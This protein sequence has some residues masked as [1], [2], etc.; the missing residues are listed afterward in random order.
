MKITRLYREV[1]QKCRRDKRAYING[2]ISEA[3]EAARTREQG[4]VYPIN[5]K[6]SV[7][8]KRKSSATREKNGNILTKERDNQER[9][10][11]LLKMY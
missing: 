7:K 8:I 3:K 1:K 2:W 5:K 10:K 9:W 4:T 11:D 6:I